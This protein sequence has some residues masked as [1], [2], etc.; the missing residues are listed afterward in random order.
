MFHILDVLV[1]FI[2]GFVLGASKFKSAIIKKAKS[3]FIKAK[4]EVEDTFK[5]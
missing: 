2:V 1:A 3:I 5:D 4:K